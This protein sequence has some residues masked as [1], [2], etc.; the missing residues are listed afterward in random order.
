MERIL[1][2]KNCYVCDK[3]IDNPKVKDHC[4]IT[5][6]FRGPAHDSCNINYKVPKFI[7]II[8]HNLE[9]YDSHLFIKQIGKSDGE[10]KCIAKNEENT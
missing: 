9:G 7:P 1:Q 10:I 2:T 5:G 4:H 6:K 8:F 3:A